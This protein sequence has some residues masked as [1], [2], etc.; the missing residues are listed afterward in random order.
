MGFLTD[1]ELMGIPHGEVLLTLPWSE[2][3]VSRDPAPAAPRATLRSVTITGGDGFDRAVVEFGTDTPFPG[4]R[5]VWGDSA[6]TG[7]PAQVS[8]ELAGTPTLLVRFEPASARDDTGRPTVTETS[9]SPALPML[10]T[11]RL[12]CERNDHLIWGFGTVA[13]TRFRVVELRTPPRL[14]IDLLHER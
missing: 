6:V 9:R 3:V 12:L 14:L 11:A 13:P 10:A 4:Y 8:P 2:N 5:I 7:C 1:A